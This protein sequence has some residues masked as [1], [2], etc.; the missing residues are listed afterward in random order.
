MATR[1]VNGRRQT[2]PSHHTHN[3][4]TDSHHI[5]HTWLRPPYLP[6]IHIW[7]DR[8]RGYC[9]L[10]SQSYHSVFFLSLYAK[11]F[12]R[13]RAQAVEQ[14][15]TRRTSRDAYSRGVVHFGGSEYN[16]FTSSPSK[17]PKKPF[18]GTYNGNLW[19]IHIRITAWCIDIPCWN[20]ARYLTLP[21][22][23]STH[24]SFSVWVTAGG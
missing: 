15:L 2:Y 7:S 17:P 14:I 9:S 21:S 12:Y 1:Q 23:L 24:K 4:L 10:Y 20:L 19:K 3:P 22:T 18:L 16:I 8:P 5:L 6:T 13:P 11:S